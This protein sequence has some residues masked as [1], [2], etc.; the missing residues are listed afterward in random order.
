VGNV[1]GRK[2]KERGEIKNVYQGV[3]RAVDVMSEFK[4]Q[5]CEN[6]SANQ[7]HPR[8][9]YEKSLIP[10]LTLACRKRRVVSKS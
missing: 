3:P 10:L 6:E 2:E 7:A 8:S 4:I 5:K 1:V 9:A